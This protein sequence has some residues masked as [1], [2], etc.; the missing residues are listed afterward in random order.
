[1]R[2]EKSE[3]F[4]RSRQLTVQVHKTTRKLRDFGFR[5]QITRQAEATELGKMLGGFIRTLEKH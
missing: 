1:M 5:D 2:F 3:V 4:K